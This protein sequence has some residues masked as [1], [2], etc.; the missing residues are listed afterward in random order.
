MKLAVLSDTHGLLR[1][2]VKKIISE[3]D[4]VLHAGD[5]AS[6]KI[7]DE[8]EKAK[9]ADA[10]LYIVRGNNDKEWRSICPITWRFPWEEQ[11]FSGA[12]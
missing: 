1:P 3:C 5:I 10:P 7:I 4:A 9:R 11:T 2:E 8:I 6:Q 12:Q